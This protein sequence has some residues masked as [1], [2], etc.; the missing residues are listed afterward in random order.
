LTVS[1]SGLGLFFFGWLFII[2]SFSL[3]L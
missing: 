3:L 1:L 2:A